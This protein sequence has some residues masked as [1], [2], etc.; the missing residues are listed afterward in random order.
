MWTLSDSELV[1]WARED[2][3]AIIEDD[4]DLS[5]PMRAAMADEVRSRFA[6]QLGWLRA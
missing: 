2:A 1:A 6:E 3:R 5:G 4:P